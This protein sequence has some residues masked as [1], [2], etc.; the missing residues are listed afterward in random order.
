MIFDVD[1]VLVDVHGS[2]HRSILDTVQHFTG[3]RFTYA[4]IQQW[5]R[6][7]GYND[8]WRLS[9]DWVNSLGEKVEYAKVKRAIPENLLGREWHARQ[10]VA[11]TLAGRRRGAWSAGP[12]A[13][14]WRSSPAARGANCG[15]RSSIL[16]WRNFSAH[17]HHGRRGAAE[18]RIPKGCMRLLDGNRSAATRSIWATFWTMRWRRKRARVP[19][20][21]VLRARQRSASRARRRNCAATVRASSCTAPTNWRGTGNETRQPPSHHERDG[22]SPAPESGRPRAARD[23]STGIRFLDHM[24]DLVARHGAMDLRDHGEGRPRRGSAPHRRRPGHRA[25]RSG[26]PGA[27]LEARHP[28]RGLFPDAHG[29]NAGVG[30]HRFQ[31]ARALRLPVALLRAHAWAI[32]KPNW[33]RISFAASRRPRR[34][35]CICACSTAA[36]RTTRWRRSSRRS[37]ARCDLRP[38]AIRS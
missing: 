2:F 38:R 25:R 21:G 16:A 6:R 19:F 24:L 1:G 18:A 13:P 22:H 7:T 28:A 33:S 32:C 11:R 4:D 15:T 17:R 10:R 26:A 23:V 5:K 8:D 20:L 14:N 34:P 30:G 3:R 37:R 12:S 29:R 35:T 31:R 9:T 36:R 27:G